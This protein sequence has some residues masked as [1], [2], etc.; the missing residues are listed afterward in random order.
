MLTSPLSRMKFV[1]ENSYIGN[2]VYFTAGTAATLARKLSSILVVGAL[3]F[4]SGTTPALARTREEARAA[5]AAKIKDGVAR[6]GTGQETEVRLILSDK[7]VLAG[8]IGQ[9]DEQ[10]FVLVSPAIELRRTI[11]YGQIEQLHGENSATGLRISVGEGQKPLKNFIR[12]L[13]PR[14]PGKGRPVETTSKEF[15]SKPFIVVLV[16]LAVGL[17]V[18]GV[19]LGKS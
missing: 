2:E 14:I 3:M 13:R 6:L 18:V 15:L 1:A 12:L 9:T 10:Q 7:S 16:V 19:E 11:A 5:L 4:V 17:I 8:F